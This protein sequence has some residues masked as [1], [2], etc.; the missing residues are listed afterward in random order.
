MGHL[1]CKWLPAGE[2]PSSSMEQ[3]PRQ[4]HLTGIVRLSRARVDSWSRGGL[5]HSLE[6]LGSGTCFPVWAWGCLGVGAMDPSAMR[7]AAPILHQAPSS[8]YPN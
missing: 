3:W 7:P 5:Q 4:S 8:D 1:L 6:V 2:S